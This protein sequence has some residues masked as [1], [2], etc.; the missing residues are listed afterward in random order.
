MAEPT[1][2]PH[3]AFV[4]QRFGEGITGGSESLARAFAERLT[5]THR[6]TV[7]TT[8][9]RDY[10]TWRNELPEGASELGQVEIL[11][12]PVERERDLDAFNAFA[13]PL[14][15]QAHG[16]AEELLFLERQGPDVPALAEHLRAH[17][18]EFDAVVFFTYLYY[19]TYWGLRA[20]PER[21][22]LVPTTHDEPPLRFG[23]FQDVFALPRAFAFLTAPEEAL[24]RSRF[25]V[26]DRPS[27]VVGI[28]FDVPSAP[29]V[30]SFRIRRDLSHPYVLYAG[31][32][33][34]GKGCAEMLRF[35]E[36]YRMD[37]AGGAEMVLIGNLALPEPRIPGVRYL[38]FL[39]EEDK[40]AAMAGAKAVVC[41]SPFES[42]SIVLLEAFAHGTPVLANARSPVLLDHCRRSN[43]GLYYETPAEFVEALDL[44][45]RDPRLRSVLGSNGRAY[46]EREYSWSAVLAR[47]RGLLAAVGA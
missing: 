6:V 13:E 20:A 29:D 35:Y 15:T 27:A 19:P 1:K 7:L 26:G 3:V 25:D 12:F 28:G 37:M 39:S 42:L 23:I 46:V 21:S 40:G 9:A 47:L 30:E 8:C 43:A 5:S 16:E 22:I 2:R 24:V 34:S 11:R 41:P 17:N 36:R 31:R 18:Q 14:Y 45:V 32:I 44:L 10:V 38:G 4:V 33:D